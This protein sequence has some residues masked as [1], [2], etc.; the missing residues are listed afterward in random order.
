MTKFISSILLCDAHE[1]RKTSQIQDRYIK[2]A[3]KCIHYSLVILLQGNALC[4][5]CGE[6]KENWLPFP[7]N[8]PWG[9]FHSVE[10][11]KCKTKTG[12]NHTHTNEIKK[13]MIKNNIFSLLPKC[14]NSE[15]KTTT[16]LGCRQNH[17]TWQSIDQDRKEFASWCR[18]FGE[19][20][21]IRLI[22]E[23]SAHT[24]PISF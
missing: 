24:N 23:G 2:Y 4:E 22:L 12:H 18:K 14:P 3:A 13:M 5:V 17:F 10:E 16:G 21:K 8:C 9:A 1:D 20:K 19:Q 7:S 6:T 11:Y 15:K